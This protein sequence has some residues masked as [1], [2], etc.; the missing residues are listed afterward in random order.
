[1]PKAQYLRDNVFS[2]CSSL[3]NVD[4][5]NVIFIDSDAFSG[6]SSLTN[7]NLSNVT[8][9]GY[10]AFGNCYN[11]TSI[12]LQNIDYISEMAFSACS[13]LTSIRIPNKI[14]ND[15]QGKE[16]SPWG[17]YNAIIYYKDTEINGDFVI[18]SGYS[19]Q[20]YTGSDENVTLPDGVTEIGSRAFYYNANLKNIDLSNVTK[21]Y[22]YVWQKY[23]IMHFMAVESQV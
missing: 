1:M 13:N 23:M 10:N 9:I 19:L 15:V 8:N 3:T 5:S 14:K 4:L 17:A 21:I 7:V 2:G 12:D 22:D 6:C 11:L 18:D 16:N 20:K